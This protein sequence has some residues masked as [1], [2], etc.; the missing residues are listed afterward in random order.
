MC[1]ALR[2]TRKKT[3]NS[4]D[5]V[6]INSHPLRLIPMI[7]KS[8]YTNFILSFSPEVTMYDASLIK[9]KEFYR[10]AVVA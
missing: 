7:Y 10:V 5:V 4:H 6:I 9:K 8:R 1:S 2:A 3:L